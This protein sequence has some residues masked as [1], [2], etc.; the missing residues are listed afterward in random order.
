MSGRWL[1][2][3]V[4]F[5]VPALSQSQRVRLLNTKILPLHYDIEL[6]VTDVNKKQFTSA[7]TILFSVLEDTNQVEIFQNGL[8]NYWL[9]TSVSQEDGTEYEPFKYTETLQGFALHYTVFHFENNLLANT[10]YTIRFAGIRGS[11]G[12]SLVEQ[13]GWPGDESTLK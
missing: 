1:F 13:S 9:G 8:L 7:G 2:I 5:L 12:G 10:N 6:S 11:F 3:F 4:A